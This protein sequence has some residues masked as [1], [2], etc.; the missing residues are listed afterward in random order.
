[1]LMEKETE[2]MSMRER[3]RRSEVS[4][5]T[6]LFLECII[7]KTNRVKVSQM[8]MKTINVIG[9]CNTPFHIAVASLI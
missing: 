7:S 9:Q 4:L 6:K 2:T 3:F 1:M 5:Q 8:D